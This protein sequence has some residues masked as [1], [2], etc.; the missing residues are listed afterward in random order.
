MRTGLRHPLQYR[1]IWLSAKAGCGVSAILAI[2]PGIHTGW[3]MLRGNSKVS[4]GQENFTQPT[5]RVGQRFLAFGEWLAHT[6]K[7]KRVDLIAY[8]KVMRHK[9]TFAAHA[10][11]R[12]IAIPTQHI[13]R[14]ASGKV[15]AAKR[16]RAVLGKPNTF[17]RRTSSGGQI[18]QKG[19]RKSA[20]LKTLYQLVPLARIPKRLR[21]CEDPAKVVQ[22]PMVLNFKESFER[23]VGTAR[24]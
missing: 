2:D 17:I 22:K 18:L 10:Y 12:N 16:P 13:K 19:R 6:H 21:F 1:P 4:F 3:A 20:P 7:M 24:R 14:T 8:E 5:G 11:G 23:A 15:G 9:G